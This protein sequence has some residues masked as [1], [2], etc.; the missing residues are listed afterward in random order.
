[1]SNEREEFKIPPLDQEQ[2][3]YAHEQLEELH[4]LAGTDIR[5]AFPWLGLATC[6]K[7]SQDSDNY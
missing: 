7:K 3:D 2:V 5:E 4:P 6:Y 1:M